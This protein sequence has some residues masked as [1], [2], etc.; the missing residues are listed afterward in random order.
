[1][2]D[3]ADV[4]KPSVVPTVD[5]ITGKTFEPSLMLEKSDIAGDGV[6]EGDNVDVSYVD[7]MVTEGVKIPSTEGLSEAGDPS[8][9]DTVDG[10][11]ENV[12]PG[13]DVVS[14]T[15]IDAVNDPVVGETVTPSVRDT[16]MEDAEGMD[17]YVPSATGFEDVTAGGAKEGMIPCVADSG[18]KT[19]DLPE[20]SAPIV[21][22]GVEETLDADLEDVVPEDAGKEKKSKK[23]KHK[24]VADDG[25][26]SE[27]KKKLSK[28][29]R[30]AKCARKTERKARR[31]VEKA[32][33]LR[34]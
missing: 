29:E 31:A 22:Q 34:L 13:G 15:V 26:P 8:V 33:K 16:N 20:R 11:M 24:K 23:M 2:P 28:E 21:S 7:D 6:P 10:L 25:E 32:Q 1:M 18:V 9:R 4:S 30:A 12:P 17:F 27:P 3:V 5:D 19:V 14:P